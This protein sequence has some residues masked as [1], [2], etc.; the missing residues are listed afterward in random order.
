MVLGLYVLVMLARPFTRYRAILVLAM[1]GLFLGALAIPLARDFY[2]LSL[3]SID[4][5]ATGLAIAAGGC[6]VLEFGIRAVNR[7]SAS[8]PPGERAV[9]TSPSS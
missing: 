2:A 9:T 3:P 5:V 7:W 8:H 1:I 6:V 4:V